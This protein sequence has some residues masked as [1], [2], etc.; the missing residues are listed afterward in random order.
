MLRMLLGATPARAARIRKRLLA[1]VEE[2]KAECGEREAAEGDAAAAH[3]R[4][5]KP[6]EERYALTLAFTRSWPRRA[7]GGRK[8]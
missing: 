6:N 7:T 5:R 1:L 8:D 2:L 3:A 4:T